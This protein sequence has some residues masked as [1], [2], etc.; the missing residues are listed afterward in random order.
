MPP[1]RLY[2]NQQTIHGC[3]YNYVF[4]PGQLHCLY[5]CVITKHQNATYTGTK[6][7]PNVHVKSKQ[8]HTNIDANLTW[9]INKRRIYAYIQSCYMAI[10]LAIY[11]SMWT[12]RTDINK[13]FEIVKYLTIKITC[14]EMNNKNKRLTGKHKDIII[15]VTMIPTSSRNQ[16][17]RLLSMWS[18][19]RLNLYSYTVHLTPHTSHLT[20]LVGSFVENVG[21]ANQVCPLL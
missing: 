11:V 4:D 1:F 17:N 20:W 5:A 16:C 19:M 6:W 8:N 2:T 14:N 15:V 7:K 21:W 12:S 9:H 13:H 3:S 10:M 18:I